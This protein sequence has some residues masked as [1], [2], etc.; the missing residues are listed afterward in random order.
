MQKLIRGP[1]FSGRHMNG[2]EIV[3]EYFAAI[4]IYPLA[5]LHSGPILPSEP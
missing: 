3:T 5:Q 1:T 2:H 4:A